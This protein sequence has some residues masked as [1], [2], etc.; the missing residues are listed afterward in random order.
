VNECLYDE[1]N[2]CDQRCVDTYDSY[3]CACFPGYEIDNSDETIRECPEFEGDVDCAGTMIDLVIILDASSSVGNS[4]NDMLDFAIDIV[5]ELTIGEFNTRVGLVRYSDAASH[6]F[7]LNS[8]YDRDDMIDEIRRVPFAGGQTNTADAFRITHMEQ[9]EY[10]RG[11]RVEACNIALIVTDGKSN[12]EERGTLP[13]S[14][15][16]KNKGITVYSVGVT[17]GANEEEVREIS[18]NPRQ[19]NHNYYMLNGFSDLRDIVD[20]ITT[21]AC[22]PLYGSYC[23]ETNYGG[24]QCFCPFGKCDH[25]PTNGTQ[26]VDIDE[27]ATANGWCEQSCT[28]TEGSWSCGC[29][30]GYVLAEDQMRCADINECLENPCADGATCVNT[31]G[32]YACVLRSGTGGFTGVEVNAAG[33]A[34]VVA[35]SSNQATIIV[36]ISALT[37]ALTLLAIGAIF[38]GVRA[39]QQKKAAEKSPDTSVTDDNFDNISIASSVS[40]APSVYNER[41]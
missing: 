33:A 1:L 38:F 26:C 18:S 29:N 2:P 11:D 8:Y 13:E 35:G 5:R 3:Y 41:L 15:A 40:A 4:W 31:R 21:Q 22:R 10:F 20:D 9:F 27:C 37:C 25:R 6:A 16:A 19:L 32:S 23:R 36:V 12:V 17:S 39:R 34:T 30:D 24:F 7:F 28:N 14:L